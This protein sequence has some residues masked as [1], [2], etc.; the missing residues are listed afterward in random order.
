MNKILAFNSADWRRSLSLLLVVALVL[1]LMATPA[2]VQAG[3]ERSKA[4]PGLLKLAHD[5]PNDTIRVIV[6]QDVTQAD[7]PGDEPEQALVKMGGKVKKKLGLINGFSANLTGKDLEK[8]VKHNKVRWVSLDAPM[9][10]TDLVT[11]TVADAF[12]AISFGGNSGNQNWSNAWQ[13]LGEADGPSAGNVN[14][15]NDTLCATG[16]CLIIGASS[17]SIE[18][19]GAVRQADL[20]HATSAQLT[21]SYRRG[22]CDGSTGSVSAQI[23]GN[24]GTSWTTL[25]TYTL[26]GGDSSQVS[27][28][29]DVSPYIAP[30]TQLR[31]IGSGTANCNVAFDN[32]QIEFATPTNLAV[33]PTFSTVRDEFATVSYDGNNGTQ[34]WSTNWTESDAAGGGVVGG[35]ISVQP[36]SECASLG[37]NCLSV[38]LNSVGD[39]IYRTA[40]LSGATSA[41]L[42][43]W[44]YN[45]I[46]SLDSNGAVALEVSSDGSTWTTL[47]TWRGV[48]ED[49]GAAYESFD[50]TPHLS[51]TTSIRFRVA[52]QTNNSYI[53]FDDIQIQY[54]PLQNT[55]NRAIGADKL[56]KEPPYLDGQGVTVAIVDSGFGNNADLQVYGGG[57]SRVI[58]ATSS[59]TGS[60]D[61][62]DGYGHGT[63]MAGILAGNGNGSSGA[64]TGVAPG[65]NL[66]NVKV[67]N[68]QGMS[69]VSDLVNGLQWIYDNRAAYNIKVVN[70]SMNSTITE[71]YHT[72]PLDAA[73]E[74]LWFNGIVVVVSAGNNGNGG[75]PVSVYPPANDPFVITVG[76]VDDQ[77]TVSLSDDT[78]SSFSAYGTT[79]DGFAKP[80]LVAPGRNV[81]SLLA[82][83]SASIYVDH[84]TYR[85]DSALFRMTGT[86]ASAPMVSGAATLL[87]QDEPNLNPDQV[88]YRLMATASKTWPGY[89][90]AKA[91]GGYLDAYA[92]VHGTTTQTANTGTTVSFLLT[93]GTSPGDPLWGSAQWGSAQWGSAQWGS[94]QWGSAQWGSAQWGSV[95][96]GSDYWGP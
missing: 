8:L 53:N 43:L 37:G 71:S 20:S 15:A 50:L 57:S 40:D 74:L 38:M 94:A 27:Q 59:V 3:H 30:N 21:Y 49:L 22:S 70:I 1:P 10:S 67:A 95:Q 87:L 82:S 89:D 6:Q 72:S 56:W 65:V 96:W 16:Y 25:A 85:V 46:N 24:A 62:T 83:T 4:P 35:N 58:T 41:T 9:F 90:A 79:E 84:P 14:V 54:T 64:R 86:S 28:T 48:S 88:K 17:Q 5:H 33:P 12:S 7:A 47:R 68:D 61:T 63:F 19:R 34:N 92:A 52:T 66:I 81:I 42:T 23:S 76:A 2:R 36:S 75:G 13:E 31:F 73:C 29:F 60:V 78:V 44:R 18:G 77:A 39:N 55:Y 80:D 93:A 32:I 91:G 11:S 26:D 69:Y 51:A 45:Q